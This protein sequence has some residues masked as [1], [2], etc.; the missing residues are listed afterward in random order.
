MARRNQREIAPE[1]ARGR[2]RF[3]AWRRTRKPKSRIPESLWELAVQLASTHGVHRTSRALRLDYYSLKKRVEAA[4]ACR[5]KNASAFIELP[6]V[7]AP[8][9][10]CVIE[11]EDGAVRLRIHLKGYNAAEIAT[12]GRSLREAS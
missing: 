7:P 12:V 11:C 8:V 4:V 9:Q 10:E 2:D 5:E 6:P 3:T 1:L